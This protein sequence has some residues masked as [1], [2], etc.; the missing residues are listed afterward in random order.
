MSVQVAV[1]RNVMDFMDSYPHCR[2]DNYVYMGLSEST[3]QAIYPV[4]RK[5]IEGK[6]LSVAAD[7]LLNFMHTAFNYQSDIQQFGRERPF[8]GDES[9]WFLY[10]D[11]E[12]RAILYSILVRDLLGIDAVL[13]EYPGHMSTAIAL[14]MEV[15]GNYL[16]I[17]GKRYLLCDPTYIG[18]HIGEVPEKY[19]SVNPKVI[20]IK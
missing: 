2:H 1:N 15:R 6:S 20:I 9:F 14:P 13:L 12:D 5:A 3:K 10:N 17:E 16:I 19:Q 11:C 8:F 18:S 4:M 7:M